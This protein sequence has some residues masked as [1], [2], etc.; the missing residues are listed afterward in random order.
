MTTKVEKRTLSVTVYVDEGQPVRVPSWVAD[1]ETFRRWVL[2]QD[3]LPE[4]A[5]V[6]WLKGNVYITMCREQLFS[7][8]RVKLR[9]A[10]ALDDLAIKEDLGLVFTDGA[11]LSNF[12]AD[13]SGNPDALFVSTESLNSQRV[14][15]IEGKQG[16]H[17]ELQGSPDLALEVLSQSSQSKDDVRLKQAYWEADI[18]ECWLVDARGDEPGFDI[19]RHTARGYVKT[20]KQE[21]WVRSTVFGKSFRLQVRPGPM[22]HSVYTLEV[23]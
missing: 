18:R 17:V 12:A 15:L 9:I 1:I 4:Q 3:D 2:E 6:W 11:L 16:G 23:R 5:R 13:I 8:N 22:K 7:H 21:G 20:R 19:F 14:R 10:A